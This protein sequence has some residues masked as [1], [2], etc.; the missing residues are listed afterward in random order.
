MRFAE[1]R[2]HLVSGKA[3]WRQY[4]VVGFVMMPDDPGSFGFGHSGTSLL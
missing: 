1:M 4:M 3:G 2:V